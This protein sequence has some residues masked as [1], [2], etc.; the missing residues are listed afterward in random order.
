MKNPL[1]AV[2]CLTCLSLGGCMS[3]W[4]FFTEKLE[5][6]SQYV[7]LMPVAGDARWEPLDFG[8]NGQPT[9]A[10]DLLSI[11]SS[12]RL[13]GV[14]FKGDLDALLGP[15]HENYEITL[16]AQRIDGHDIFLGLTFPVGPKESA[17]LVLGG[18]GGSV[19]GISLVD[20]LSANENAHQTIRH[21]EDKE[22][23]TVKLRVDAKE[24]RAWIDGDTLF[25]VVR[26]P[27]THFSVRAEVEPT[28]PLGL[29]TF[30]TTA[31]IRCLA[32]RKLP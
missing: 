15:A 30:A 6:R 9:I 19:C 27:E 13:S 2:A 10:P 4:P 16:Q 3:F 32:V 17:S 25:T 14:A 23:H 5:A 26:K 24:I 11:P 12:E 22:W 21:F 7:S 1:P 28:A 18:W 8:F 20:G 31:Q 29:F